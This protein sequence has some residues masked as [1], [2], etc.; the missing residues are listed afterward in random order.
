MVTKGRMVRVL[1]DLG[2][3][4]NYT[5]QWG[6]SALMC[7]AF[8][9]ETDVL[10]VLLPRRADVSG[11]NEF[12]TQA[13]HSVSFT[14]MVGPAYRVQLLLESSAA[15]LDSWAAAQG[16]RAGEKTASAGTRWRR[17]SRRR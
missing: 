11:R 13:L 1:L 4:I 7:S 16:R 3:Q 6:V 12:G 10:K 14:G 9:G 5:N 2:A 17:R 8:N 15:E